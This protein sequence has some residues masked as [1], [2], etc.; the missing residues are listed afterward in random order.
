MLLASAPFAFR[1]NM[2]YCPYNALEAGVREL[3]MKIALISDIHGNTPALDAVLRDAAKRGVD[4]YVFA[5]DYI[6]DNPFPNEVTERLRGFSD[7]VIIKGN[8]ENYLDGMEKEDPSAWQYDQLAALYWT[9]R[10]LTEDNRRWLMGLPQ[11]A[12]LPL[13]KGKQLYT[14]HYIEKL[15]G[16]MTKT[17]CCSSRYAN[18][19]RRAPFTHMEYLQEIQQ[20]Q[21]LQWLQELDAS[22][23]VT[24]HTH[25][26]WY[27]RHG[28]VLWINPGSCGQPLDFDPLAPYSIL[29][30]C[31]G[32]CSVEELRVPY[33]LD[34]LAQSYQ[35]TGIREAAPVWM[36]LIERALYSGEDVFSAMFAAAGEIAARKGETG[37]P[38]ANETWREA[39]EKNGIIV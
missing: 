3:L 2:I 33:D 10:E 27:F 11:E 5:G 29:H 6:F 32:V 15:D 36:T 31:D 18:R 12:R 20:R 23:I 24:G 26:Q 16:R 30:V 39:A 9:Y 35:T 37:T 38:F 7:A 28:D 25:L 14:V 1:E 13:E 19:M 8:K 34:R 21:D 17:D 4:R 22:V